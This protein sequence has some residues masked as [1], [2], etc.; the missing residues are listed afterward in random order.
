MGPENTS[1]WE[2]SGT[3]DLEIV[4]EVCL[5]DLALKWGL[6]FHLHSKQ[7]EFTE[8]LDRK[9]ASLRKRAEPQANIAKNITEIAGQG[10]G[11]NFGKH[12]GGMQNIPEI[13]EKTAV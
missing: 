9:P 5:S 12:V 10:S 7:R 4:L 3:A 8:G 2:P 11:E 1:S 13:S 6:D